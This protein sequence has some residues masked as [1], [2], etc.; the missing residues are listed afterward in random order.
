MSDL[1]VITRSVVC[2]SLRLEYRKC[3]DTEPFMGSMFLGGGGGGGGGLG[4]CPAS[5]Q[6]FEN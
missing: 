4:L 5:G 2:T 6:N 1:V 3:N